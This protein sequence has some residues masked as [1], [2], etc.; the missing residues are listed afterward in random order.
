MAVVVGEK[1]NGNQK[2]KTQS[3]IK[4]ARFFNK[5]KRRASPWTTRHLRK[6]TLQRP[7]GQIHSSRLPFAT[8][9]LLPFPTIRKV[10]DYRK[11]IRK[12]VTWG[13]GKFAE[14]LNQ[15]YCMLIL[16]T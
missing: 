1:A 3:L 5:I 13:K 14:S 15:S 6:S 4:L 2:E 11:I 9:V 10:T 16:Y 8:A 7:K 12:L